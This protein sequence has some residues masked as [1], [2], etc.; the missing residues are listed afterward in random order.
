M[1]T[2]TSENLSTENGMAKVRGHTPK[3]TSISESLRVTTFM[4][5]VL[6]RGLMDRSTLESGRA[7]GFMAEAISQRPM[8]VSLSVSLGNS[9]GGR[10]LTTTQQE[11]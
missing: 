5:K 3:E 2:S 8:E 7:A 9:I 1:G 6:T 10:A 11:R 4:A